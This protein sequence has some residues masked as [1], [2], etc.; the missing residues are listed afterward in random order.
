MRS[1]ISTNIKTGEDRVLTEHFASVKDVP[2]YTLEISE[3]HL[4]YGIEENGKNII[5]TSGT[6]RKGTFSLYC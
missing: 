2:D 1:C 5:C 3:H 6:D 4:T